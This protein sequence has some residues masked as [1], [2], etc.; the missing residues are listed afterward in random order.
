MHNI[1]DNAYIMHDIIDITSAT[2][3]GVFNLGVC[4]GH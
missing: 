2:L 1:I 4:S 3:I